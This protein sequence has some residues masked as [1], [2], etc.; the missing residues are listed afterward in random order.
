M[1]EAF[2]EETARTDLSD[3]LI[4]LHHT[5]GNIHAVIVP[6]RPGHLLIDISIDP[7]HVA[8]RRQQAETAKNKAHKVTMLA[9]CTGTNKQEDCMQRH[10]VRGADE[11]LQG[12]VMV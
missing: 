7:C 12:S 9:K 8:R 4:I 5:P 2:Q 1:A 10:R 3:N 6:V 11:Q